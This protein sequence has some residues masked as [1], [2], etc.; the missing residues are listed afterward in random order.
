MYH[1]RGA[2][3]FSR[4]SVKFEGHTAQKIVEFDP[5]WMFPDCNSSLISPMGTTWC[6]ELEVA[7]NRCPIV[8]QCHLSS[9]KVTLLT[10]SSILTQIWAF[11]DCKS[12]LSTNWYK[13]VDIAWSSK[14]EVPYLFQGYPQ[15]FKV[16]RLKKYVDF[17]LNWAFPDCNWSLNGTEIKHNAWSC[18]EGVPYL[19][20]RSSVK[21]QGHMA[22]KPSILTQIGHFRT[23]APVRIHWWLWNDAHGLKC[24]EEVPFCF[25]RSSVKFQGIKGHKIADFDPN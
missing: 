13:M 22:Q 6:S 3:S 19:F 10:K 15:N 21:F 2:L 9:L 23:V 25:S 5:S 17:D 11:P 18:V 16:T 24:I 8:F 7:K 20:T 12:S 4:S 1:R 14:E